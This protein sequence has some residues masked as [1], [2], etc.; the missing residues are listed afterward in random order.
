[1]APTTGVSRVSRGPTRRINLHFWVLSQGVGGRHTPSISFRWIDTFLLLAR[2]GKQR[3]DSA[4]FVDVFD[5]AVRPPF[6]LT[7]LPE[8][9]QKL[10]QVGNAE[11]T[12]R[13]W[14]GQL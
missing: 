12:E 6:C 13:D 3:D 2:I 9:H 10:V 5:R 14:L 11:H 7:E 1:M 4:A 8:R